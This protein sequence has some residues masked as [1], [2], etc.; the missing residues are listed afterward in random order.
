M[1]FGLNGFVYSVA[2]DVDSY[3]GVGCTTNRWLVTAND[4]L[5]FGGATAKEP[6]RA[7]HSCGLLQPEERRMPAMAIG[8]VAD[9]RTER[10]RELETARK[11]SKSWEDKVYRRQETEGNAAHHMSL[12]SSHSAPQAAGL[13]AVHLPLGHSLQPAP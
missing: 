4:G 2:N 6:P 8:T 7:L 1:S 12:L 10:K 13:T 11:E 9:E 3:L 5:P